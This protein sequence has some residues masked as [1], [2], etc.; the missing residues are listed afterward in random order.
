MNWETLSLIESDNTKPIN[1]MIPGLADNS[2]GI[3]AKAFK[4]KGI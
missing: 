1:Y 3:G 4:R 2:Q